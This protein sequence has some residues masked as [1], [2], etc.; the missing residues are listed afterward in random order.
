MIGEPS[1]NGP[2]A[3]RNGNGRFATG[4]RYGK[5]GNPFAAEALKVRRDLIRMSK[6][7]RR[8]AILAKLIEQ[9][10]T[11]S[12]PHVT[13]WLAYVVGRPADMLVEERIAALEAVQNERQAQI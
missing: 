12:V 7:K 5:G 11:G 10:A 6:G 4:N 8:R 3:G 9:A 1:I 2:T 13:L